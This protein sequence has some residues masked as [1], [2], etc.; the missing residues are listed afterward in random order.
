[1]AK[2]CDLIVCSVST[3]S[4]WA[5][6]LSTEPYLWYRKQLTGDGPNLRLDWPQ[7]SD[8][9]LRPMLVG[10]PPLSASETVEG[11]AYGRGVPCDDDGALPAWLME[12][13]SRR[14][15]S[16]HHASDLVL[17]GSLPRR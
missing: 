13:L 1:M 9:G 7:W 8:G 14:I 4:Q 17:G 2:H 16:K 15:Y 3:Y 10:R 6:F 12:H 5:A 11:G